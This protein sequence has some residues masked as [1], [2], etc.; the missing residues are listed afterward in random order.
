M[1]MPKPDAPTDRRALLALL[2]FL[3]ALYC[4][5]LFIP[6]D[7]WIQ[8]E[9][10]YGEVVREMLAT[11]HWL[12]PHLNGH[13]YPDKPALY[14]WLVAAM[15]AVVGQGVM[16]F[17]LVTLF[18]TLAAVY[19][20]LLVGRHLA[21]RSAGQ[22]SAALFASAFLTLFVGQM[23]RMDML[24]TASIAFAWYALLSYRDSG[25]PR[26]L[27]G[28]WTL[29]ILGVTIKGPIALLF[30]VLP[31]LAWTVHEDGWRG[32]RRLRPL[33]GLGAFVLVI[34]AWIGI[35]VAR[36]EGHYL[37][38]IWHDQLVGRAVNSWSHRE[39]I[40][41]YVVL[42]PLL[43]MP[44]TGLVVQGAYRL[45][46]EHDSVW[47]SVA[48][49]A[50]LPLL[51]VSLVSGKLF[52]YI[53]PLFP[54]MCVAAGVGAAR[55]WRA[56][57]PSLWVSLPPVLFMAA[58]AI[59]VVLVD[60]RLLESAASA[61]VLA[62]VIAAMGVVGLSLA[63][64]NGRRWLLGWSVLSVGISIGI[65]GVLIYLLN[66]LY[67]GRAIGEAIAQ[68]AP[69]GT[70]VGMVN[71][72][73]GILNYYAGRKMTEL[74]ISQ[75]PAWWN[76]HPGALMIVKTED[77]P[78]VLGPAGR[79]RPCRIDEVYSVELKQYHLLKGCQPVPRH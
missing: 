77:L 70:P 75:A 63:F 29:V 26:T 76:A 67:S 30:S 33:L 2:G 31:A 25:R 38:E 69:P 72:T 20:V 9:A 24:L 53:E 60:R 3:V 17:R 55:L 56:P 32:L 36:G 16:A 57:R 44:W 62:G 8:D 40:Y 64:V 13:F 54:A 28:F 50:L 58:A 23:A 42:A 34:A 49:F 48:W 39:P 27:V 14:F 22:W 61:Q 78:H 43:L 51:G 37:W 6:R 11:G 71:T 68:Q 52:I 66:P 18:S 10:R 21:G 19:G 65:F 74:E 47:R 59:A 1:S 73:R 79:H 5:N 4:I 45:W 41:F 15:G 7:L 12:I 46:R 35:V